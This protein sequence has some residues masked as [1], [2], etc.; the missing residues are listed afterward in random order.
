MCVC[1]NAEG[2]IVEQFCYKLGLILACIAA[3]SPDH[4]AKVSCDHAPNHVTTITMSR[5]YHMLLHPQIVQALL[6]TLQWYCDQCIKTVNSI[7]GE[8][9]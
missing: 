6:T 9:H 1:V 2:L 5:D 7:P 4:H 8:C 3:L